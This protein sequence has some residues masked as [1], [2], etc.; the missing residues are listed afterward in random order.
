[1][2]RNDRRQ[3]TGRV[4]NASALVRNGG[5]IFRKAVVSLLKKEESA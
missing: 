3:L 1:M 5:A 4:F 2:K